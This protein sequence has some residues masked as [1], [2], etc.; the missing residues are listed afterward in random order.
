MATHNVEWDER[1]RKLY[2]DFHLG[3][4]K[5][6]RK[7]DMRRACDLLYA[8]YDGLEGYLCHAYTDEQECIELAFKDAKEAVIELHRMLAPSH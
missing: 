4:A 7:D 2:L 1:E 8:A 3:I 6:K 5:A